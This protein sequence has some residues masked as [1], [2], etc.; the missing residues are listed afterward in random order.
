MATNEEIVSIA[1]NFLLSAPPGEFNEIV[2]DVR[3]LL[4]P[5][6]NILNS[7]AA[8]TFREYNTEQMIAVASPKGHKVLLT[9]RGEISH[10]EYLDPKGKVVITYDHI[11]QT[12]TGS[13]PVS[14][15]MDSDVESYRAAFE[16]E[17]FKYCNEFYPTGTVTVYGS[18]VSEGHQITVCLSSSKLNPNN[19]WNGRW[20]STWTCTFK[21]NSGNVT[22]NGKLQ[23]NVHYYEDGNVQLNT[24]T[25]KSTTAPSS[26]AN[27]TASNVFKAIGRTELNVHSSLDTSYSTMG[28]TTF[29]ALRRALPI[30][31]LKINWN[32]IK[33]HRI[34]AE[35]SQ[36][37]ANGYSQIL[38]GSQLDRLAPKFK[39]D[40]NCP[41]VVYRC[42]EQLQFVV[43][44][45]R[46]QS[47]LNS[48]DP[49][50]F[51]DHRVTQIDRLIT[52]F[53][54]C[55]QPESTKEFL[56]SVES[57]IVYLLLRTYL[58][59]IPVP[60]LQPASED[61]SFTNARPMP[62]LLAMQQSLSPTH[63]AI[64]NAVLRIMNIWA[65][66][67]STLQRIVNRNSQFFFAKETPMSTKILRSMIIEHGRLFRVNTP[68]LPSL[69]TSE[70]VVFGP[71]EYVK[72]QLLDSTGS[73]S[74]E[75]TMHP[76]LGCVKLWVTNYR[77]L[78]RSWD[79][80]PLDSAELDGIEL[81]SIMPTKSLFAFSQDSS[82]AIENQIL[83]IGKNRNGFS[84]QPVVSLSSSGNAISS[85]PTNNS[86][87]NNISKITNIGMEYQR[88]NLNLHWRIS[89][90]NARFDICPTYSSA[91]V[92]PASI[93]DNSLR[94]ISNYRVNRRFPAVTWC[95]LVPMSGYHVFVAIS[96]QPSVD[97]QDESDLLLMLELYKIHNYNRSNNTPLNIFETGFPPKR[98]TYETHYQ[99][100]KFIYLG[101]DDGERIRTSFT[102]LLE[103]CTS[104]VP[105]ERNKQ[106]WRNSLAGTE[107]LSIITN[108]MRIV[109][110][111]TEYYTSGQSGVIQSSGHDCEEILISSLVQL[112]LDPFYRTLMGVQI[113]IQKEWIEFGLPEFGHSPQRTSQV[114]LGPLLFVIFCD[115][116]VQLLLQFPTDFE[117]NQSFVNFI[118]SQSFTGRFGT[119]LAKSHKEAV[120]LNL[121]KATQ[122]IWAGVATSS[123]RFI[124]PYYKAYSLSA[125]PIRQFNLNN[126]SLWNLKTVAVQQQQNTTNNNNQQL[127]TASPR[128]FDLNLSFMGLFDLTNSFLQPNITHV[129][130]QIN[131]INISENFLASIPNSILRFE[132]LKEF[133]IDNNL[134]HGIPST[135]WMLLNEKIK[136]LEHLSIGH[137]FLTNIPREIGLFITLRRLNLM[138]NE[139]TEISPHISKLSQLS[140]L[141]LSRN[142]LD[143]FGVELVNLHSLTELDFSCNRIKSLPGLISELI[144]LKSL[145]LKENQIQKI[146]NSLSSLVQLQYLNISN[147]QIQ[148]I[149]SIVVITSLEEFIADN[150]RIT[151]IPLTIS[152][153]TQ[154]KS[155]SLQY[156]QIKEL[157][158]EL[159]QLKKLICLRLA[160]NNIGWLP[161]TISS[162]ESLE[163]FLIPHNQLEN[164]PQSLAMM[165]TITNL[166]IEGNK[167]KSMSGRLLDQSGG[168][169]GSGGGSTA[170]SA[171][172]VADVTTI[173]SQMKE[174]I[175]SIQPCLRAKMIFLGSNRGGRSSLCFQLFYQRKATKVVAD[176]NKL[177]VDIDQIPIYVNSPPF[178]KFETV[179]GTATMV[180]LRVWE[181]SG[182]RCFWPIQSHFFTE[183]T[184]YVIQFNFINDIN[185]DNEVLDYWLD[186]VSHRY[187]NCKIFAIGIIPETNQNEQNYHQ[188]LHSWKQLNKNKYTDYLDTLKDKLVNSLPSATMVNEMIP[189]PFVLLEKYLIERKYSRPLMTMDDIVEMAAIYNIRGRSKIGML[190][191]Y[192]ENTGSILNFANTPDTQLSDL[193]ITNTQWLLHSFSS[194]VLQALPTHGLLKISELPPLPLAG[195][196]L[197]SSGSS[198]TIVGGLSIREFLN[199][200]YRFNLISFVK[201]IE[202][203]CPIPQPSGVTHQVMND[204]QTI[205][206]NNCNISTDTTTLSSPS[207]PSSGTEFSEWLSLHSNR[208][209]NDFTKIQR[210]FKFSATLP[211]VVYSIIS[212]RI[213]QF[214]KMNQEYPTKLTTY[215]SIQDY[216]QSPNHTPIE[217]VRLMFEQSSDSTL[218]ITVVGPLNRFYVIQDLL[219]KAIRVIESQL[220]YRFQLNRYQILVP[221]PHCTMKDNYSYYNLEQLELAFV[222]GLKDAICPNDHT[223]LVPITDIS[224][225][226]ALTHCTI[227]KIMD[228]SSIIYDNE[229]ARG[230]FGIVYKGR[231]NNKVVAIKRLINMD[232]NSNN[233]SNGS[234]SYTTN[235][236][237]SLDA[238]LT[239]S[240]TTSSSTTVEYDQLRPE[241]NMDVILC[242]RDFRRELYTFEYLAN[243]NRTLKVVGLVLS[244]LCLV[245]EFI[246]HGDLEQFIQKNRPLSYPLSLRIALD[247]AHGVN[248]LHLQS[249]P[250]HHNDLKP[251]N[252]LLKYSLSNILE[253][254]YS[255]KDHKDIKEYNKKIMSELMENTDSLVSI[256]DLGTVRDTYSSRLDGRL[257]D[258]PIYLA[259]EIMRNQWFYNQSVDVYSFGVILFEMISTV[260]F[261][262]GESFFGNVEQSVCKGSRPAIPT[263]CNPSYKR[264]INQC[265]QQD[266]TQRPTFQ[267]IIDSLQEMVNMVLLSSNSFT[268]LSISNDLNTFD[269]NDNNN[270]NNNNNNSSLNNQS[271]N[272]NNQNLN[273]SFNNESQQQQQ[274]QLWKGAAKINTKLR[275]SPYLKSHAEN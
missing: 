153:M 8:D 112:I 243:C 126:I 110:R 50:S 2:S 160:H 254:S 214:A 32:K 176:L 265:W 81:T 202:N 200:A 233:N 222:N 54:N 80:E 115:C 178:A 272:G 74:D 204:Y 255:S 76:L 163:T 131:S 253:N 18:K 60:L 157:P 244:P 46:V 151:E 130:K 104:S 25:N 114:S 177:A 189:S 241:D 86:I 240:A 119:F 187:S 27:T 225:D 49:S 138:A 98:L 55:Q 199:L 57:E 221:C 7:S 109:T 223:T 134:I 3:T 29:K 30:T 69:L 174:Y 87:S 124:N 259:P 219:Y 274:Q 77:I 206:V 100:C 122:S 172:S 145:N 146:P 42:M 143:S 16:E 192:L 270:S 58:A 196:S 256:A 144:H 123:E 179:D 5:N 117:F 136:G 61:L 70:E 164:L 99:Q 15:E 271:I 212:Q 203:A 261:F 215:T 267:Q 257:V 182:N 230:G 113:L 43:S 11:K 84:N 127:N 35:L 264:L 152:R 183:K 235:S 236:S 44:N 188:W 17:A 198:G 150:N 91:I 170:N 266:H 133:I 31:K 41:T 234:G 139:I 194:L 237:S 79:R 247:I 154:L 186:I 137:N 180:D 28:D 155:L 78:Y 171:Q 141:N 22:L 167:L 108:T 96:Q 142:A 106:L 72:Y 201:S 36:K 59:N 252:L 195:N 158:D 185:V 190:L 85:S 68:T 169:S 103:L 210:V 6:E 250:L 38:F 120:Q 132:N 245:T 102:K 147:N 89:L 129:S 37:L 125:L 24:T 181:F 197:N 94:D 88:M 263:T 90:M 251:P 209:D 148:S 118:C 40:G 92:L 193:F 224:S 101:M 159:T 26:D 168:G 52:Q 216:N 107:W 191:K 227:N 135:F 9:K 173:L 260:G 184:I 48:Y 226:I 105:T 217:S 228:H 213:A 53:S 231:Y 19:F 20:R 97:I 140:Y 12:V 66:D 1:T 73:N 21:P 166:D 64:L 128:S 116:I 33:G 208:Y 248:E 161:P 111:V 229:L 258:N 93:N 67:E 71:I 45:G 83:A 62:M 82:S 238:L 246:H 14:G 242:F 218:N 239:S 56:V 165:N 211:T 262:S 205:L 156:N 269:L 275:I 13:R 207:I 268:S 10:N 34:G 175:E 149:D 23:I 232:I 75:P 65:T 63:I 162:L 4:S 273:N 47:L 249:P 220:K 95:S 39:I 51:E 121:L